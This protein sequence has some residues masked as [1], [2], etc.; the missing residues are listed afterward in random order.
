LGPFES[1]EASPV[2]AVVTNRFEIA[3]R[4][5]NV[6]ARLTVTAEIFLA[7]INFPAL[8]STNTLEGPKGF[9]LRVPPATACKPAGSLDT[10]ANVSA[11]LQTSIQEST[12]ELVKFAA[13]MKLI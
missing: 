9:P 5:I 13:S 6:M 4:L 8:W 12:P 11:S 1:F 3:R 7:G 2:G 10:N